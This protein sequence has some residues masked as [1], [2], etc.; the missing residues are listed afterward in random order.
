MQHSQCQITKQS[1]IALQTAHERLGKTLN[2][3]RA[4]STVKAGANEEP[5]LIFSAENPS[6]N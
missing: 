1:T 6:Y 5:K 2:G 3:H 4:Y